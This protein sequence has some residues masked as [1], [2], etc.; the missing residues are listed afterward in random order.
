MRTWAVIMQKG[1]AG[2]TVLTVSLACHAAKQGLATLAI[3]LDRQLSLDAW[4]KARLASRIPNDRLHVISA[5]VGELPFLLQDAARQGVAL[6]IIDAAPHARHGIIDICRLSDLVL[7]PVKPAVWDII[8]LRN[9]VEVLSLSRTNAYNTAVT[10]A[11]DKAIAVLNCVDSRSSVADQALDA[12]DS[13][14]IRH[15][16]KTRIAE[17]IEVRKAAAIGQGICEFA[18]HGKSAAEFAELFTEIVQWHS[19]TARAQSAL[20]FRAF[21]QEKQSVSAHDVNANAAPNYQQ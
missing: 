3:N 11:L 18:S 1:G 15:I 12:L 8:A 9:T 19:V 10:T 14:G 16:C 21:E 20:N 13:M 5:N 4:F 6:V 7:M 17:R 2:R